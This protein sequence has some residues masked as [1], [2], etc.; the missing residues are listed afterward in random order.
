V[1]TVTQVGTGGDANLVT[2]D[3]YTPN[4]TA[5]GQTPG[6]LVATTIDPRGIETDFSYTSFGQVSQIVYA[7]GTPDQASVSMT[8]DSNENPASY[9]NELGQTILLVYDNSDRKVGEQDPP[10]DPSQPNVRPTWAWVYDTRGNQLSEL[11]PMNRLTRRVYG[12]GSDGDEPDLDQIIQPDPAGGTNYT[13]TTLGHDNAENITSVTDPMQR[14]QS[15]GFDADNRQ[16]SITLPNPVGG[17]SG[18]PTESVVYNALGFAVQQFDFAGNETDNTFNWRGQ[19]LTTT[20]PAT[21]PGAQRPTETLTYNPDGQTLTDQNPLLATTQDI[22]DSFGRLK[23]EILPDPD[24]GGPLA[25]PTLHWG[26]DGDGNVTSYEDASGNFYYFIYNS[27]NEMVEE[28]DPS[29]DGGHT[30]GPGWHW[31][32]DA[33]GALT[34]TIDPM[35]RV[36]QL[37]RDGD[38]NAIQTT[39]P[40]PTTGGPGDAST[41]TYD[42]FD[43][44]NEKLSETTPN[45]ATTSWQ[46]D[47]LGRTTITTQPVP[48]PGEAAPVWQDFYNADSELTQEIDPLGRS[49]TTTLDG[50]GRPIGQTAFTGVQTA[51]TYNNLSEILTTTLGT[52]TLAETSTNTWDALGRKTAVQD[53]NGTTHMAFDLAGGMT[54][55]ADSDSNQTVWVRDNLGRVTSEQ[56]PSGTATFS[57]DTNSNLTKEVDRMGQERDFVFDDLNR[58][59]AEKW[60]SGSTVVNTIA[61]NYNADG[62]VTSTGDN[63]SN[64]AFAYSGQG[65]VTSADNAGTPGAPHVVLTSQYDT[66]GDRT[67]LAATLNGTADF[68]NS[69]SFDALSRLRE[70]DQQGQSGGNAVAQKSIYMKLNGIGEITEIDRSNSVYAGPQQTSPGWTIISY[71]TTTGLLDEINDIT[72]GTSIDDLAYSHDTLGRIST[73]GSIDGTATYGYD[74]TSQIVSAAYTTAAGGHQPAN[75]SFTWDPNGNNAATGNVVSPNNEV[76][77]DGTSTYVFDA[78]GNRTVRTRISSDYASDYKTTYAWDYRNRLTDV[79]FFDNNNVLTKHVHYVYSVYDAL[80]EEDIDSTGSGSYDTTENFVLDVSP[81]LPVQVLSLSGTIDT[82]AP[83]DTMLEF[84]DGNLA[85]RFLNAPAPSGND[86]VAADEAVES[87][88]ASGAVNWMLTNNQGTATDTVDSNGTLIQHRVFSDFGQEIFNSNPAVI[89]LQG[90]AGGHFDANTGEILFGRRWYDPLA[91][92]WISVDSAGLRTPDTNLTRYAENSAVNFTDGSGLWPTTPWGEPVDDGWNNIHDPYG[93]AW[94]PDGLTP[95]QLGAFSLAGGDPALEEA[96]LDL[97]AIIDSTDVTYWEAVSEGHCSAWTNN[98]QDT[99]LGWQANGWLHGISTAQYTY[100]YD[101]WGWPV[102]TVHSFIRVTVNGVSFYVDNDSYGGSDHIFFAIPPEL[103]PRPGCA[104]VPTE[105]E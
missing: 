62:E 39:A 22:Y 7:V 40:N 70:I 23:E 91:G 85:H 4:P 42:T 16:T 60:M 74:H 38:S 82:S 87:L 33:T 104:S 99:V 15:A 61:T 1:V 30:S 88:A 101:G 18:G 34:E 63:Y 68:I 67:S 27:R 94:P 53:A 21:T 20:G 96:L 54:S 81:K 8:Y 89:Q 43:L 26:H 12:P 98:A 69:Y 56:N 102:W 93:P 76:T 83:D 52:G 80:I 77:N 36:T 92:V 2:H 31:V 14:L 32:Y 10:P 65:K 50:M 19:V 48:E 49:Q 29:P 86:A 45:G 78:N 51:W 28:D 75:V 9:T 41:T 64:Y 17:G 84:V 55:L 79:E 47:D 6:G 73:F 24:G 11:D 71:D 46:R 25:A 97:F 90:D 57:Y 95:D 100:A 105:G 66:Q 3:T 103:T 58:E 37:V 35:Q 59:T 5:Q 13:V 72:A 44:D